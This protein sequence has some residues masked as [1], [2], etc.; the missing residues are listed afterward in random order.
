MLCAV[1]ET[2]GWR[3]LMDILVDAADAWVCVNTL[4]GNTSD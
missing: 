4:R 1:K 3:G 2:L